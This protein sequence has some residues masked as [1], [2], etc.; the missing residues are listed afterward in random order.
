[1]GS[2]E[3]IEW[4]MTAASGCFGKTIISSQAHRPM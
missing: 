4:A 2:G 1:V 3:F